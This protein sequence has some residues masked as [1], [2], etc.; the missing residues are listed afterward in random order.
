MYKYWDRDEYN[1][2]L[3]RSV[4]CV[5]SFMVSEV[6]NKPNTKPGGDTRG[7]R[8]GGNTTPKIES[9]SPFYL[10]RQDCLRD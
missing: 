6:W 1:D 8:G 3:N 4:I 9:Y 10:G 7:T 5:D 2:K